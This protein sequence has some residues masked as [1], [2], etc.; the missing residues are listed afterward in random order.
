TLVPNAIY[1]NNSFY[2][3]YIRRKRYQSFINFNVDN[4]YLGEGYFDTDIRLSATREV[5]LV[6]AKDD[7]TRFI[8][9]Y[10]RNNQVEAMQT[11]TPIPRVNGELVEQLQ[12]LE[13]QLVVLN[14]R[15]LQEATTLRDTLAIIG[16]KSEHILKEGGA[17]MMLAQKPSRERLHVKYIKKALA[18]G[19]NRRD[20]HVPFKTGGRDEQRYSIDETL[21]HHDPTARKQ[22]PQYR[23]KSAEK[24]LNR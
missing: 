22:V 13:R 2:E 7:S 4:K 24:E 10:F 14:A 21:Q 23:T 19:G 15:K 1:V 17:R 8:I 6:P 16:G 9:P 18:A 12:E 20:F 5:P 3:T 11:A